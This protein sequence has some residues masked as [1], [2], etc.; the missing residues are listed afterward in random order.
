MNVSW[1]LF[2]LI[3]GGLLFIIV[4]T[5]FWPTKVGTPARFRD[6]DRYWYGRDLLYNNPDDLA[7]I[8]PKRYTGGYTVN[9]GHPLGKLIMIGMLL[10]G[11]VLALLKVLSQH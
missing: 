5:L 10:L 2:L 6:D 7:V 1:P 8:V 4:L 11:V 9:F 3:I